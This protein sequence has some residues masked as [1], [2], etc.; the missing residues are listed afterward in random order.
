MASLVEASGSP[1]KIRLSILPGLVKAGSNKS[2]RL[3]AQIR[4]IPV[5]FLNPSRQT[6]SSF[7]VLSLSLEEDSPSPERFLPSASI[8]SIKM[9]QGM[10]FLARAKSSLT[11]EEPTPTYFSWNSEPETAIKLTLASP[12]SPLAS[13]VLPFPGGPSKISP[14]GTLTL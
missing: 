13:R 9:I 10:F 11:L 2:A 3:V 12:A 7:N 6:S 14:L 1:I 8:S 4:K 5:L